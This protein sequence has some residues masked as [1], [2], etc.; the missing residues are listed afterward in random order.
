MGTETAGGR[1]EG[2]GVE[3]GAGGGGL[4]YLTSHCYHW[5]H[6]F[7]QV[8]SDESHFNPFTAMVSLENDQE[9]YQI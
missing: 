2:R 5:N 6:F 9:K 4:L 7:V 3:G 1:R 8:G